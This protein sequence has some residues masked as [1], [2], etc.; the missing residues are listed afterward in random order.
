MAVQIGHILDQEVRPVVEAY[1]M[2]YF[3]KEFQSSLEENPRDIF[4]NV[5]LILHTKPMTYE[6]CTHLE[7][8]RIGNQ[9]GGCAFETEWDRNTR[10]ISIYLEELLNSGFPDGPTIDDFTDV[11]FQVLLHEYLHAVSATRYLTQEE[12]LESRR[13]ILFRSAFLND[14]GMRW[15]DVSMS[16]GYAWTFVG[17]EDY[18][19]FSGLESIN[20]AITE[21]ISAKIYGKYTREKYG[22]A[23][24]YEIGYR[25]ECRSFYQ[26]LRST[27][28]SHGK[29]VK[30]LLHEIERGYLF[31]G[32]ECQEVLLAYIIPMLDN[33]L[34]TLESHRSQ[35]AKSNARIISVS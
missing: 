29:T 35:Y 34:Q 13:N 22:K 20:E 31:A 1:I 17:S 21:I 14:T 12:E 6:A 9:V 2:Q 10:I 26:A 11:V 23:K 7:E 27:A 32:I 33:Y 3:W 5:R 4:G 25:L 16:F 8:E 15:E 18:C 24:S 30:N 19:T 28:I